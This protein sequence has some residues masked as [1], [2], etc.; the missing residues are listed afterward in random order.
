MKPS[1][2]PYFNVL[3]I[4]NLMQLLQHQV[5]L[6]NIDQLIEAVNTVFDN[7]FPEIVHYTFLSLQQVI[8]EGMTKGES[9]NF[10]STQKSFAVDGSCHI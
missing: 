1:N 8:L 2:S 5:A 3:D 4:F 9:Y 6:H 7:I 10:K